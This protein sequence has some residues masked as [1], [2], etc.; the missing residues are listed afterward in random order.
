[1]SDR[2]MI[3]GQCDLYCLS[4]CF[5]APVTTVRGIKICPCLSVRLSVYPSVRHTLRYSLCNQVLPQFSVNLFDTLHTC[6][7]H[8]EDVHVGF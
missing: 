4:P 7:G 6:C 3:A 2:V 8:I 5:Y 1:M